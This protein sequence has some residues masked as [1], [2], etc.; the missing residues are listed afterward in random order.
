MTVANLVVAEFSPIAGTMA[1]SASAHAIGFGRH[2]FAAATG[3]PVSAPATS[4]VITDAY[5]DT[6]PRSPDE[7]DTG[8]ARVLDGKVTYITRVMATNPNGV[9]LVRTSRGPNDIADLW[10]CHRGEARLARKS[11][12]LTC[13]V[14][15]LAEGVGVL[16]D[17]E[18]RRLERFHADRPDVFEIGL[19]DIVEPAD[20]RGTTRLFAA[21]READALVIGGA[22]RCYWMRIAQLAGELG[23]SVAWKIA[24]TFP[25]ADP[26][27]RRE[28]VVTMCKYGVTNVE[29]PDGKKQFSGDFRVNV[30]DRIALV[31]KLW[32]ALGSVQ[33]REI[34]RPDGTRTPMPGAPPMVAA[35]TTTVTHRAS[36]A[37]PKPSKLPAKLKTQVAA[38]RA[39]GL[40]DDLTDA[41][42]AEYCE[43]ISRPSIVPLLLSYYVGDADRA[44][45]DRYLVHDWRFGQETDDVIA[46][47]SGLLG[48][49]PLFVQLENGAGGIQVRG[50]DGDEWIQLEG[51]HDV[52]SHFNNA[53]ARGTS[54]GD[55]RIYALRT[56]DERHAYFALAKSA[57]DRLRAAGIPLDVV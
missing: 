12:P 31:G 23:A 42:L 45:R 27:A 51:L 28:G 17:R 7:V 57:Y 43:G 29:F 49:P 20:Y 32:E 37:A 24:W 10:W 48:T 19:P 3:A 53:L 36:A 56:E 40:C 16:L 8:W 34:E 46:E 26:A 15:L 13:A 21:L 52:V 14:E 30:G 9:A 35:Q 25:G 44:E 5:D 54:F 50:P 33:Y 11:L 1:T 4:T 6:R 2:W 18:H 41:V 47:L 38:L 22:K 55:V 39:V